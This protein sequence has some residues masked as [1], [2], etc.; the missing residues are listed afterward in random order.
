MTLSDKSSHELQ[1]HPSKLACVT[2]NDAGSNSVNNVQYKNNNFGYCLHLKKMTTLKQS[3]ICEQHFTKMFN[4]CHCSLQIDSCP[5]VWEAML[6]HNN[7]FTSWKVKFFVYT[8]SGKKR[9][10]D[11]NW[12][13][14]V[15][16]VFT[17]PGVSKP[18]RSQ[19][20]TDEIW[21]NHILPLPLS[22]LKVQMEE[23]LRG[24]SS[25]A[26]AAAFRVLWTMLNTRFI[27]RLPWPAKLR[28]EERIK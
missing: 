19:F 20:I 16:E 2:L 27:G 23:R 15:P 25:T 8:S 18:K 12:T 17:I 6:L 7:C 24:N 3:Q 13:L 5:A 14:L 4:L 9:I 11:S 22:A 1:G 26:V 10:C 21:W 28:W